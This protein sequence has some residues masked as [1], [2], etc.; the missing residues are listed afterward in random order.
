MPGHLPQHRVEFVW[1]DT[2]RFHHGLRDRVGNDFLEAR[3]ALMAMP[4]K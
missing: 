4:C 3:F 1:V 2:V